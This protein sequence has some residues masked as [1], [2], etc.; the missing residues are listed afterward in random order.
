MSMRTLTFSFSGG[1][2]CNPSLGLVTKV[3]GCKGVGQ[4]WSPRVTF[5][6]PKSVGKCEGMTC[7]SLFLVPIPELQHALL[8]SKCCE[9]GSVPQFLTLSLFSPFGLIV[10][11]IKEFGGVSNKVSLKVSNVRANRNIDWPPK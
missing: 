6:T 1:E 10:E 7:L 5:H 11:S 3:R 4:V 9:P 8:P 2:C